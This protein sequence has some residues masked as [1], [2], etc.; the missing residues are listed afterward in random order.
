[1]STYTMNEEDRVIGFNED[2]DFDD[3]PDVG[4]LAA[5]IG[6]NEYGRLEPW[7]TPIFLDAHLAYELDEAGVLET[8]VA[9]PGYLD[10]VYEPFTYRGREV[11]PYVKPER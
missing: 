6:S 11:Y 9:E 8:Y 2:H 5:I 3:L 10:A 4:V 1:M 7:E